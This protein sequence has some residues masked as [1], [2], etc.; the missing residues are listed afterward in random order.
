MKPKMKKINKLKKP[1]T[2]NCSNFQVN[3]VR[4]EMDSIKQRVSCARSVIA[5]HR[6]LRHP[7]E[8]PQKWMPDIN[9]GTDLKHAIVTM[10]KS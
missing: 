10:A 1:T 8:P 6:K 4:L 2:I 7:G 9:Q 3:G 5:S